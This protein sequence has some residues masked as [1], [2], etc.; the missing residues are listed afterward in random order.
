MRFLVVDEGCPLCA[1]DGLLRSEHG[2]GFNGGHTV[3]PNYVCPCI[4]PVE[5]EAVKEGVIE[6]NPETGKVYEHGTT[7]RFPIREVKP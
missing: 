6:T 1:G 2:V 7:H 5:I 4:H 3:Y